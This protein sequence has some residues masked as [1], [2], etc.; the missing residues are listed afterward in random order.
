MDKRYFHVQNNI[1]LQ[2]KWN[3]GDIICA[4]TEHNRFYNSILT[5]IGKTEGEYR[6]LEHARG[7]VDNSDLDLFN[8]DTNKQMK[9]ICDLEILATEFYRAI[10]QTN[11]LIRENLFE[12]VRKEHYSHRPSRKLGIWLTDFEY[13][14]NWYTGFT[15]NPRIYELGL[16]EG[17]KI[18]ETDA[19][20]IETDDRTLD[21]LTNSAHLY[22]KAD[23]DLENL[24]LKEIL[25][26]GKLKV[27]NEFTSFDQI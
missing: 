18:F 1:L 17:G 11:K 12:E 14:E 22:W 23:F 2:N 10:S 16:L 9:R 20:L 24:K 19:D 21:E 25:Y 13:L 7:I 4:E 27:L 6:L 5:S 26:Q 8:P 15:N 3:V